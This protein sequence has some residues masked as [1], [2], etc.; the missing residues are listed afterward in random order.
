MIYFGIISAIVIIALV[1]ILFLKTKL[2]VEYGNKRFVLKIR[3]LFL[4]LT[5]DSEKLSKFRAK[6][7]EKKNES[8][9]K[10]GVFE[11][12]SGLKERYNSVRDIID[13]FSECLKK[14]VSMTK[15]EV[16]VK[17]GTGDACTTGLAYGAIWTL[18]GNIYSFL[19]RRFTI[20]F[21][22]VKIDAQFDG[23]PLLE[24]RCCGIIEVRFVHIIIAA[25]RSYKT[26]K[27]HKK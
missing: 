11:K 24:V 6:K 4:R 25:L 27:K 19:C 26:Y 17:Y 12:I 21:P 9:E 8:D 15:I 13:V 16:S 3:N 5:I 10:Q 20:T 7:D 23:K 14:R 22:D 1:S 18:I 2:I